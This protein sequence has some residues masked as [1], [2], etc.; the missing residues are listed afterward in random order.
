MP[1]SSREKIEFAKKL[2]EEGLS[3][4]EIQKKLFDKFGS[5][6]SNTTIKNLNKKKDKISELESK[7]KDLERELSFFKRLYFESLEKEKK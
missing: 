7:I 6:M 4:D 2:T 5:G 3:Y 1:R